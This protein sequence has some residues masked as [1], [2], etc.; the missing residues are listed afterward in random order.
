MNRTL[1]GYL[2]SYPGI[3]NNSNYEI[4]KMHSATYIYNVVVGALPKL[5]QVQAVDQM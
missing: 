1:K 2:I 5:S 4:E 3:S